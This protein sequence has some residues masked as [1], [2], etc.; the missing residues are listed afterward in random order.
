MLPCNDS[1]EK[2]N[3]QLKKRAKEDLIMDFFALC[4]MFVAPVGFVLYN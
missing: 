1:T 3:L 4:K 2:E